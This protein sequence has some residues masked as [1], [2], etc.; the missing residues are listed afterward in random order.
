EELRAES[1]HRRCRPLESRFTRAIGKCAGRLLK[2]EYRGLPGK[3]GD[4][5]VE[6]A[7][8]VRVADGDSHVR[9]TAPRRIISATAFNRSFA[10]F[11]W[12]TGHG[13]FIDKIIVRRHII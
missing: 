13:R 12:P 3:T 1:Q 8:T 11:R 7:V 5:K 6:K 10:E 9:V 4:A 2:I